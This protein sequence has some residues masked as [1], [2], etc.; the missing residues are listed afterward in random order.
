V[1]QNEYSLKLFL[2]RILIIWTQD[3]MNIAMGEGVIKKRKGSWAWW[4]MP[5]IPALGRQRQVDF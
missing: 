4:H 5:L 2:L 1:N 3:Y